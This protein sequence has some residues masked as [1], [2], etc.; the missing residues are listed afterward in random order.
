MRT[1]EQ[2]TRRWV[3]QF[4]VALELCPFARREVEAGRVRYAVSA[5]AARA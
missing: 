4:V 5:A 1:E 2:A 3:E